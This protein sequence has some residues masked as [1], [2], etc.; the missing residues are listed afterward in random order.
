[1]EALLKLGALVLSGTERR[2]E[3]ISRNMANISTPGYRREVAFEEAIL[4]QSD[5]IPQSSQIDQSQA[6]LRKTENPLDLAIDGR[7]FFILSDGKNT[8]LSRG[9]Q[10]S[11]DASGVMVNG[12][13]Y[14]LLND[15]GSPLHLNSSQPEILSDGTVLDNGVSIGRLGLVLADHSTFTAYGGGS[16]FQVQP[17]DYQPFEDGVVR[18]GMLEGSNVESAQEMIEL[19][20]V[21]RRAE[22]GSKL[23][24]MYDNL[25]GQAITVLGRAGK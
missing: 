11:L 15:A 19:M 4:L 21:L 16:A 10:F 12:M 20:T 22:T 13:G 23:V 25:V 5:A 9:G 17:S 2:L 7:G 24:Q 14:R 3:G 1:M 8:Y 18:Q 6:A